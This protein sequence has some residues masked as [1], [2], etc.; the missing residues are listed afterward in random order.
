LDFSFT[1]FLKQK[2]KHNFPGIESSPV[3][4]ENGKGKTITVHTWTGPDDSR[5]LRL[6]GQKQSAHNIVICQSQAQAAFTPQ[7][8]FRVLIYVRNWV[9]LKAIVRP[10]KYQ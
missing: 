5:K 7:K 4:R 6:P 3:L 10:E 2:L 1:P 8:I 9:N